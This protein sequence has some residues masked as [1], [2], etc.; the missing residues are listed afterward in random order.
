MSNN[1]LII[2]LGG[3]GG[4]VIKAFRRGV[5]E[6]FRDVEPV[7]TDGKHHA[8]YV[9]YLY[10]DSSP[11]DLKASEC[12]RTQGDIGPLIALNDRNRLSIAQNDLLTRLSDP[13]H[14]PVTHR[15]IG[16]PS[17]WT[18]IF[19]DAKGQLAA[20]G[21]MRRLGAAL[22]EPQ[23]RG[24]VE[25]VRTLCNE[26]S[27]N[28]HIQGVAFHVCCGLAGGT[29]AG[30]FLHVIAQL[31]AEYPDR[32]NYPIFLYLLLPDR[33]SPWAKK[34]YYANASA[35]LQELN[36]YLLSD[37]HDG[38][39][40]GGPLFAPY[41]L[42]GQSR[43]FENVAAGGSTKLL[44]R[45]QGCFVLS[46]VNERSLMIGV[47]NEEIHNLIAQM[48]F[49]R[50]FLIDSAENDQYQSL[51]RTITLE[52]LIEPDECQTTDPTQPLRSIRSL[53]AMESEREGW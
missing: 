22:F 44:N 24:F 31:R 43:R 27:A 13:E 51:R 37:P 42:T 4:K 53:P 3:T 9:N 28:S 29:G 25:R 5:Y 26:L 38:I 48:Q 6:E 2:G 15:Y 52:N 41:D 40:K 8:V 36:A 18:D 50:I 12:W 19:N 30:A 7:G 45:L 34:N 32:D 1:H 11:G 39:N 35:A 23:C 21:Q 10:L 20:G 33:D 47:D 49:Q 46:N 17:L 14:F 16:R